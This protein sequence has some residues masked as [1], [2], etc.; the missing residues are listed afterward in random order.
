M[1]HT[2]LLFITTSS[3]ASNP[4]LVK[5]FE[6]LK[7]EFSCHVLCFKHQDWSMELS[8]T[9][10]SNNPEVNFIEIDRKS[11]IITTIICKIIHKVSISI[12]STFPKSFKVCAFANNDK[13]LQLWFKAKTL[14]KKTKFSRVIAHNLGAFYAAVKFSDKKSSA[15]QLDIEDFYPGEALYFNKKIEKQN[16]MELMAHGFIRAESITYASKGIQLECAKHFNVPTETKQETIINAFKADDFLQP[17]DYTS[18]TIKAVWFSQ[19]IG[20]NRGLEQVFEAANSLKHIE[21]HLIGNKN[22]DYLDTFILNT[23]V[24]VH[25]IMKQEELHEFLSHMDVGLAL[26]NVNA[27]LN[28]DICLTNKFLAYAQAG[29]YILATDTFGQTQFMNSLH[30]KSGVIIDKTLKEALIE[31]DENEIA[32]ATKI[33]RWQKAKLFA[34]ETEQLKLKQLLT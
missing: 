4:R 32:I 33:Q 6:V 28:R 24:I 34:W 21:F 30:Y 16:R 22:Q 26:E 13:A 14:D 7:N 25:D 1:N 17:K 10:K 11:A 15:L 5:E 27:D 8:E 2:Q 19:H 29:L 20:P 9:I 18:D 23:N 31:L 3:L 12:N